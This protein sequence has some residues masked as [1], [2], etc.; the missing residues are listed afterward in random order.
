MTETGIVIGE[1]KLFAGQK[2]AAKSERA[3]EGTITLLDYR[4]S[5]LSGKK[6]RRLQINDYNSLLRASRSTSDW[7]MGSHA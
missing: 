5:R 7:N 3:V 1:K 2:K 4:D 6:A